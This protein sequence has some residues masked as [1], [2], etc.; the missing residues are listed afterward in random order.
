MDGITNHFLA[1]KMH[2][3]AGF[4][5][6]NLKN[7]PRLIVPDPFEMS[8]CLDQNTN[9]RLARQPSHSSCLTKRPPLSTSLHKLTLR[10]PF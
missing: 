4:F 5:I 10:L 9:F 6:Y 3:I 8:Q 1:K 2:D 7:F